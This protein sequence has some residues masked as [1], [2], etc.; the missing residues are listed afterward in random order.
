[1]KV[2]DKLEELSV[3]YPIKDKRFKTKDT[4]KI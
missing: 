1:M 4:L 2:T 3:I